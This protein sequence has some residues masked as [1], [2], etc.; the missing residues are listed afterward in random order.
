MYNQLRK[1]NPLF[2]KELEVYLAV[3]YDLLLICSQTCRKSSGS[4]LT[5]EDLIIMPVQRIPRYKLL[6]EDFLKNTDKAHV[7]YANLQA[8]LSKVNEVAAFINESVRKSD[9]A[10]KMMGMSSKGANFDVSN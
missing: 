9:N 1:D 8:A 6:L 2:V 7:D 10:K 4:Q 3:V 5:L